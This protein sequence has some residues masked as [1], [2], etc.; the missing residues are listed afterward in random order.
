M[1]D[2][3]RMAALIEACRIKLLEI[4]DKDVRR[5]WALFLRAKIKDLRTELTGFPAV[6][7]CLREPATDA[8]RRWLQTLFLPSVRDRVG[9]AVLE[10]DGR[11][12]AVCPMGQ[13]FIDT[14]KTVI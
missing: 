11:T 4:K 10:I 7:E 1:A 9:M 13:T 2:P 5:E 8:E 3:D 12:Y 6:N 14:A